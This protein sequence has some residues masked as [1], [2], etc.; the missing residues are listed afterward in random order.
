MRI[1]R[2][3]FGLGVAVMMQ[4]M[5]PFAAL[6]HQSHGKYR[7]D[8]SSFWFTDSSGQPMAAIVYYPYRMN[9]H[10]ALPGGE[11]YPAVMFMQGGN[12]D[13]A[14]YAWLQE[15]AAEGYIVVLPDKYPVTG[16]KLNGEE[17]VNTNTKLTNVGVL[18]AAVVQ[19]HE[20]AADPYSPIHGRFDGQVAVAGHSWGGVVAILAVDEQRCVADTGA[21]LA[22][23]PVGYVRHPSISAMWLLGGHLE[24]PNGP[25]D[26]SPINK[27]A[28]FPVYL[29][30]GSHDE[31]STVEEVQTTYHRYQAPKT[32]YEIDGANHFG[33]VD[34]LH[35]EDNLE[36]E[37]PATL[38]PQKQK[39][40]TIDAV[41]FFMDCHLKN[42][43]SSACSKVPQ[44]VVLPPL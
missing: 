14:R 32:Y 21:A 7:I 6:A 37:I 40:D 31:L 19:L 23:C 3:L 5:L 39:A 36:D 38:A 10:D 26:P 15:L 13:A 41:V 18:D 29:V 17:G 20:W 24:N 25:E 42:N 43:R 33:W 44:S 28:D 27:P 9:E 1:T 11:A 22:Q 2:K 12:V 8:T 30:A 4:A 16:P 35:P 34:Y